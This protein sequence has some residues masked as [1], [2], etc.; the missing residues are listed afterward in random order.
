M[1][2]PLVIFGYVLYAMHVP[3]EYC[4]LIMGTCCIFAVQGLHVR[5]VW[6]LVP[7]CG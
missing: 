3:L 1:L 2:V 4:G 7:N 5:L 6:I